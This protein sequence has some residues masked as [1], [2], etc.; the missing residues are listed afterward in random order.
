MLCDDL[1][2][3]VSILVTTVALNNL[4]NCITQMS[5][6]HFII[7]DIRISRLSQYQFNDDDNDEGLWWRWRY[8]TATAIFWSII[9]KPDYISTS[10]RR[11]HAED[12]QRLVSRLVRRLAS[13]TLI[14]RHAIFAIEE[15]VDNGLNTLRFYIATT[16]LMMMTLTMMTLIWYRRWRW[17]WWR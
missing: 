11:W 15:P 5:A 17:W 6:Y 16:T 12:D 8:K 14:I 4:L 2:L 13:Q 10:L 1:I 9:N 7:S 3:L